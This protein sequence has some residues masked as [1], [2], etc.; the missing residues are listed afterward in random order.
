MSTY[1]SYFT[2]VQH[3]SL[4]TTQM[5]ATLIKGSKITIYPKARS[6]IGLILH[7]SFH[8]DTNTGQKT[9][10]SISIFLI[11]V[12][13]VKFQWMSQRQPLAVRW[14]KWSP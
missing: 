5:G 2:A 13:Y 1:S 3:I 7:F 14:G 6:K 10:D 12:E 4:I 8:A 9:S 11:S